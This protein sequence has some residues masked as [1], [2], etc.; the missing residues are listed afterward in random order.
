MELPEDVL[1]LIREYARPRMQFIHEYNQI[2]R[3]LGEEWPAVKKKLASPDAER[4]LEQFAYYADGVI[5][6][7]Q[8]KDAVPVLAQE[9]TCIEHMVWLIA[10]RNYSA[11]LEVEQLRRKHLEW[12]LRN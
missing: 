10:S 7:R 12:L 8:S 2:V 4:V 1:P 3:L 11:Y 6:A 5:M 9:C